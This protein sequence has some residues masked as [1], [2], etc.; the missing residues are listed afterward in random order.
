MYFIVRILCYYYSDKVIN[1]NNDITYHRGSIELCGLR[2][3]NSF[4]KLK[5]LVCQ[6]IGLNFFEFYVIITWRMLGGG[7][8]NRY[9][10]VSI[11]VI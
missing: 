11:L 1:T 4:D 2:L 10:S 6:G 8:L 5:N 9:V 3:N 7:Y